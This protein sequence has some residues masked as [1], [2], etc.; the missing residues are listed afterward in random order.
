MLRKGTPRKK[1]SR[2]SQFWKEDV[3]IGLVNWYDLL[4]SAITSSYAQHFLQPSS[5]Q[6]PTSPEGL[7]AS[8]IPARLP[9]VLHKGQKISYNIHWAQL[10]LNPA[11]QA[12]R[13]ALAEAPAAQENA[14]LAFLIIMVGKR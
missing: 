11:F 3:A 12:A 8:I 2:V 5:R 1:E 7:A 6:L 4:F 14:K 13:C 10:S 9:A